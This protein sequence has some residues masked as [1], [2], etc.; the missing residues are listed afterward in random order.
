MQFDPSMKTPD[1]SIDV[2]LGEFHGTHDKAREAEKIIEEDLSVFDEKTLIITLNALR[3]AQTLS[4]A[5]TGPDMMYAPSYIEAIN[6][7]REELKKRN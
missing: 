6:K 7:V 4:D 2:S 1:M 5:E 3:T